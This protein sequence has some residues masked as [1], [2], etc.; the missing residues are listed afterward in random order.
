MTNDN[1]LACEARYD[2]PLPRPAPPRPARAAGEAA[3]RTLLDT[4]RLRRQHRPETDGT[5]L[6]RMIAIRHQALRRRKK[7]CFFRPFML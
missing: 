4:L 6:E 3:L 1:H 5:E 7:S 2:G